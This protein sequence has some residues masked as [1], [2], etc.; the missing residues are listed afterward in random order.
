MEDALADDIIVVEEPA[1][2]LASGHG[3][4]GLS[5][6]GRTPKTLNP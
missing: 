2:H 1:P 6:P 3:N 4:E 5:E